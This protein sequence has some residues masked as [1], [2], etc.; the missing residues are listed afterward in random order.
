MAIIAL[1]SGPAEVLSHL[2]VI[3]WQG[4]G[5]EG[6]TLLANN[7]YYISDQI[8]SFIIT[9]TSSFLCAV[10]FWRLTISLSIIHFI[11]CNR[12]PYQTMIYAF[13]TLF[14][15]FLQHLTISLCVINSIIHRPVSFQNLLTLDLFFNTQLFRIAL[16]TPLLTDQLPN[17]LDAWLFNLLPQWPNHNHPLLWHF[18][19]SPG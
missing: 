7:L 13:V 6:S 11:I 5:G 1:W 8:F 12:F 19:Y 2:A 9:T 18:P 4:D 14:L 15:C 10:P 17:L 3:F 16:S